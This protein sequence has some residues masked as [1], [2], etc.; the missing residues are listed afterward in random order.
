MT[1]AMP[2]APEANELLSRDAFALLLAM[3]LDQQV[4]FEKAF[5]SPYE[6]TLRL[7]HEP[8]AA[9]SPSSIPRRWRRSSPSGRRCT[10]SPRPWPP[11]PRSSPRSSPTATT[12]TRPRSGRTAEDAAELRKRLSALPG[13]GA[14][15]AQITIAL[16]GKQLGVQPAGWREE[17]GH[18]GEEGSHYS[19]ADIR[20]EPSLAAVRSY[21]KAAKQQR[22]CQHRRAAQLNS[23]RRALPASTRAAGR[24]AHRPFWPAP[25]PGAEGHRRRRPA[26]DRRHRGRPAGRRGHRLVRG[27][28]RGRRGDD[29]RTADSGRD[30]AGGQRR[31][32]RGQLHRLAVRPG[33]AGPP[34]GA[35]RGRVPGRAA[36]R[37]RARSHPGRG[38]CHDRAAGLRPARRRTRDRRAARDLGD[39]RR[40]GPDRAGHLDPV[41]AAAADPAR[42]AGHRIRGAGRRG[43]RAAVAADGRGRRDRQGRDRPEAGERSPAGGRAASRPGRRA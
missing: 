25:G 39:G 11:G 13:F 10:G 23:C 43:D 27:A 1:L 31:H 17:A 26:A 29:G 4:P 34:A 40:P 3:M 16:L 35:G 42:G 21:K 15:K 14:Y 2:I 28:Q 8:T 38:Q 37:G 20:D 19:V 33:P 22:R 41:A 32:G 36:G 18:F 30:D 12:V 9:R 7:G 6:L 5:G 24:P